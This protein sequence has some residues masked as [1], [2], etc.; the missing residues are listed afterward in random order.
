MSSDSAFEEFDFDCDGKLCLADV[1]AAAAEYLPGT[2][3][4]EVE[5]WHEV[6]AK[7]GVINLT[8]W[9]KMIQGS[10]GSAILRSRGVVFNPEGPSESSQSQARADDI[11]GGRD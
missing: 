9:T 1:K 8:E 5:R 2:T 6:H 3:A 10:D 11:G 4:Y 7:G